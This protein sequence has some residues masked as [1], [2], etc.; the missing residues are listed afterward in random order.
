VVECQTPFFLATEVD[1][2]ERV[3]VWFDCPPEAPTTRGFAGVLSEGLSGA[4]VEEV[5][6]VPVDFHH[7]MGL[8]GGDQPAAAAWDGR[9]PDPAAAQRGSQRHRS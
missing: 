4:T 2:D 5:L 8:G 7:D 9:D 6:A 3:T 1:D